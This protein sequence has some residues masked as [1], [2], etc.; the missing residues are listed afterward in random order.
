MLRIN[1]TN[2]IHQSRKES[3][4]SYLKSLKA[5]GDTSEL[6]EY[7]TH[8]FWK[9]KGRFYCDGPTPEKAI[10]FKYFRKFTGE[11]NRYICG[12]VPFMYISIQ[13]ITQ[14]VRPIVKP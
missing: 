6:V 4:I 1:L 13:R 10:G 7:V 12:P 9:R 14:I 5:S 2:E 3:M 8:W 11:H